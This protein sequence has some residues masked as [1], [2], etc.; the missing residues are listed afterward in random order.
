MFLLDLRMIGNNVL[1]AVKTFFHSR[2]AREVGAVHI[3]MTEFT[4]DLLH[5]CVDP[6]A[7][8]DRLLRAEVFDRPEVKK[9][10]AGQNDSQTGEDQQDGQLISEQCIQG[11]AYFT[12]CC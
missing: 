10:K 1:V 9:V 4:L 8:R 3:R 5:S 7:E 6:V 2:D 12:P 11:I